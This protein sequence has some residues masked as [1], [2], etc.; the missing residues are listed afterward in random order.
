MAG[1]AGAGDGDGVITVVDAP[2][3]ADGRFADDPDA[4]RE[5]RAADPAVS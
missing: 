5:E 1:R 3:V 2:A 4:V